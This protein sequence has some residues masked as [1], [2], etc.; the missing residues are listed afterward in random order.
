M[1]VWWKF[2]QATVAYCWPKA[3]INTW[4]MEIWFNIFAVL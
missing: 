2:A 1:S 3:D 4:E